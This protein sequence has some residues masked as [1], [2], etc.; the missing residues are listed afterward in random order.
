M[1]TMLP[2]G[3][4]VMLGGIRGITDRTDPLSAALDNRQVLQKAMIVLVGFLASGVLGFIR[5][6]VLA[7]QFGVAAARDSF[8][9]AQQIPELVFVL[10][11]GGALGSSFIPIYAKYREREPAQAWQLASAVMTLASAAAALLGLLVAVFAPQLVAGILL[12]G[13]PIEQ[14]QLTVEMIRLM[15]LT[16]FIFSISGLVMGI[17]QSHAA[18]WLP[19]IAISMNHIGIIIGAL[20][21]APLAARPSGCGAGRRSQCRRPGLWRRAER[22]AAP[23][24]A[25]AGSLSPARALAPAAVA[26]CPGRAHRAAPDGTARAR[27]WPSCK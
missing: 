13:R 19:A 7:R 3:N 18:F 16:P 17:L 22:P 21:I 12:P 23:R 25:A 8:V 11:A 27:A 4:R 24:R 9:A 26:A 5:E 1:S 2:S 20:F 10:V 6:A 14:Q 15:M